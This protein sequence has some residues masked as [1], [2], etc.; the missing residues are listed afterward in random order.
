MNVNVRGLVKIKRIG[1]H[2]LDFAKSKYFY[3]ATLYATLLYCHN[4]IEFY[5][6]MCIL[7]AYGMVLTLKDPVIL[8][9]V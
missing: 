6:I 2:F 4:I 1:D 8:E 9:K 7:S 5:I 3:N